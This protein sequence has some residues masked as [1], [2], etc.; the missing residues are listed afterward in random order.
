MRLALVVD[1]RCWDNHAL[2]RWG[3]L[4]RRAYTIVI[5]CL[6]LASCPVWPNSQYQLITN[7]KDTDGAWIIE[8]T[9]EGTKYGVKAYDRPSMRVLDALLWVRSRMQE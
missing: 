9:T 3:Y 6:C 1:G 7:R 2:S 8:W 4:R 5:V